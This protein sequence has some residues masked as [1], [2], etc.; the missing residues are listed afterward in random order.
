[1]RTIYTLDIEDFEDDK[2]FNP[3]GT[4]YRVTIYEHG[5]EIGDG[6]ARDLSLAIGEAV[7][8]AGLA[9][10]EQCAGMTA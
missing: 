6:V 9:K 3:T 8:E 2:R 7:S 10:R 1:M 4:A 5:E